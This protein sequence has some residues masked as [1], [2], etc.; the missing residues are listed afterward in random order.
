[1]AD[2]RPEEIV[3][4][5]RMIE[6]LRAYKAI[7]QDPNIQDWDCGTAAD[8]LES[9]AARIQALTDESANKSSQL[10]E[11]E[12]Q[13]AEYRADAERLRMVVDQVWH[14]KQ[15]GIDA[16]SAMNA[17]SDAARGA[18]TKEVDRG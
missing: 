9:Q 14:W 10:A 11:A 17:I 4:V 8:F 2:P 5:P 18:S 7:D 3:D 1:M 6:V 12:R 15:G 16:E 13:L